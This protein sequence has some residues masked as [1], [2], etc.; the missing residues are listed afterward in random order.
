[1][2]ES[3]PRLATV[4]VRLDTTFM[5]C[6]NA[7]KPKITILNKNDIFE[8]IYKTEKITVASGTGNLMG[9]L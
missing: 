9:K 3:A 7:H 5:D 8:C 6:R 2:P 4:R 1:M